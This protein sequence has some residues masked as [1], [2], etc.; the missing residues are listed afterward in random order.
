MV[1]V[2]GMPIIERQIRNLVDN[3]INEIYVVAGY[4]ENVLKTFIRE[5]YPFVRVIEN[6]EYATTNNMFSLYKTVEY[7]RGDE[8]LL[9]NS[10]VFHDATVEAGLISSD[11]SNMIACEYGRYLD[12]SMKI[13]VDNGLITHIG[14]Q[15]SKEEAYATSIDIY[16]IGR[17]A[18][19]IL[20]DICEEIIVKEGNCNSWTEVALDKMFSK[21]D[22]YP[23]GIE[24]RWFEID[25][26]DDLADAEKLFK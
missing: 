15:I 11:K 12:E 9:M 21:V 17:D 5:K 10:D 8:F 7:V 3:K 1:P 19:N 4:K 16:K 2:N 23:Y 6:K 18:G 13:S 26:H 25:N 14:K 24:G 22:F 20:F